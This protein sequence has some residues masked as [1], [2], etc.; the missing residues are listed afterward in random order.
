MTNSIIPRGNTLY[1]PVNHF[2]TH[3]I[4][5]CSSFGGKYVHCGSDVLICT[6]KANEERGRVSALLT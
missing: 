1:I 5:F 4:S 3:N 6:L 2:L